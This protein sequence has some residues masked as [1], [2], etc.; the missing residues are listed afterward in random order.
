MAAAGGHE[1]GARRRGP[2]VAVLVIIPVVWGYNWVVMKRALAFIGPFEFAAW[3]FVAGAALLFAALAVAGRSIRLGLSGE[4]LLAGLLQTAANTALSLWAL[5]MGPAGRSAV[6][7]YTMPFWVLLLAWPLLGERPSR[8][9][10]VGLAAGM[11]GIALVF[12]SSLGQARAGAAVLAT[13][14]GAAWAGGTV[15]ARR[16]LRR[17][18]VDAL[19]FTAWQMLLGGLA[20]AA[21]AVVAPGRPTAWTPYLGFALFYEI[22]PATAVAWVLWLALLKHVDAGTA[23]LAVL[24]SPALG[25]LFGAAEL[26]ERPAA[27]EGA[28]MALIGVALALG[29]PLALRQVQRRG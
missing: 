9:Q 24:A 14:S 26:G 29:G 15:V 4:A 17:H 12:A 13:L 2:W 16:A 1:S 23:S 19:A 18:Q 8:L 11:L 7:C 20:L 3:R 28:G 25:L 10:A 27:A 6:L 5:S 22:V 21:A